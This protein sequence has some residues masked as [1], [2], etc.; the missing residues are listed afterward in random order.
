MCLAVQKF[1]LT[2]DF[3]IAA[4][5]DLDVLRNFQVQ[6]SIIQKDA[7][8]W[9]HTIVPKMFDVKPQDYVHQ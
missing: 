8:W 3:D 9:L 7:V 2:R 5:T 1:D 4:V 6:V